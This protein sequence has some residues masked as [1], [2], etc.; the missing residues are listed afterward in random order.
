M[1][2][3]N[4]TI[5]YNFLSSLNKSQQRMNRI[6]EQLSDGKL[7]H[8]PSDDPVRAIRSLRLNTDLMTNDQYT[9]NAK[10]A[11]SWMNQ[12]DSSLGGVT[13][14]LERARELVIDAVSPNPAIA[15]TTAATEL[16]G[17]INQAISQANAQNGDRYI[18]AGQQDKIDG[19]P[20]ER[21]TIT[22]DIAGVPTQT[23]VVVY[24]GDDN[25]ISMRLQPGAANPNQDSVNVTGEDVFGPMTTIEDAVTGEIY[26]VSTAFSDLLAIKEQLATGTPDLTYLSTTALTNVDKVTD[27]VM[28]A[29]TQIGTRMAAYE[30]GQNLLERNYVTIGENVAANDDIDIAKITIDFKNSENVYNAALAVGAKI[31]PQS[32]VD[33]LR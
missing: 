7:V 27:R 9:Q 5:I 32:L 30:M 17:L 21:K 2:I 4:S 11:Q 33:F 20:F 18:F 19:G 25:K 29:Q 8:R 10:D 15:Y 13:D 31:M 23:E 26:T 16:D 14:V 22:V 24:K 1:R 28:L 6:Q 3:A 12:T